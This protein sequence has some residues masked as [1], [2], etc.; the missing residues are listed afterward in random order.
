ML[1]HDSIFMAILITYNQHYL[2]KNKNDCSHLSEITK[3]K[4]KH[5]NYYFNPLKYE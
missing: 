4:K 2:L 5:K 3:Q 1:S